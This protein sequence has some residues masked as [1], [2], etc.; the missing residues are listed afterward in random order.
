MYENFGWK[1]T[2]IAFLSIGAGLAWYFNGLPKGLDLEG[3][4][5]IIYT[6]EREGLFAGPFDVHVE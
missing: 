2:L 5:E 4:V 3:G 6:L 1:W